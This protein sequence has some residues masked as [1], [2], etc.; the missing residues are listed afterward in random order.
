MTAHAMLSASGSKRWMTCTPSARLES[1]LPEP[2]RKPGAFDFSMEGTMAHQ[3]AE[4]KLRRHYGQITAKEYTAEVNAV[5]DTPFYDDEFEQHVDNYVVYVRSQIGEGDVPLFE[6]RVDFSDWVP[7]GF[8]TADVVILSEKKI[9]VIDLKFGRG[10]PVDATDNPQLRLYAL[11]AWNKYRDE[12]PDIEA[13]EY[14]IHQPRLDSITTDH[15]TLD[16]L[17]EW[18]EYVVK[19]KAK[20][21]WAGHGDFVPG[22]HCQFCRAKAQ[23]RARADFNNVAAA[24]DFKP[25]ELLAEEELIKVLENAPQTRKWL[26]DVESYLLERAKEDGAVPPGYTLGTS[27]TN[28]KIQNVEQA[29]EKLWQYG[30]DIYEPRTL[31]SVA[32]LEKLVGKSRLQELLNELIVRPAGEPKLVK[33]KAVEEFS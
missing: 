18:A 17:V 4:A 14:T 33:S 30:N 12:Y 11:G 24:A 20:K 29:A 28:R 7:D 23:C 6:Q 22:D 16:K 3:L 9:R 13:I 1:A 5:K 26:S 32:Q 27:S 2:K 31:K 8:G 10:V 15:T 25:P 21:A 19:P